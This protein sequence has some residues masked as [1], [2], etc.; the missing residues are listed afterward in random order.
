MKPPVP[1][2]TLILQVLTPLLLALTGLWGW[3]VYGSIHRTILEGFDRKLLALSGGTAAFID[4]DAHAVYQRHRTI[5]TLTGGPGGQLIGWDPA[6]VELLSI[7]PATGGALPLTLRTAGPI[8][9]LA[10]S[11][12]GDRLFALSAAGDRLERFALT[13]ALPL[14]PLTPTTRL[15]GIYFERT[16]LSGWQGVQLFRVDPDTGACSPLPIRLPEGVAALCFDAVAN[17]LLGLSADTRA[18]VA[19]DLKGNVLQ[20]TPFETA[21][22]SPDSAALLP[23]GLALAGDRLF[24]G[25]A[26]LAAIEPA[27]G[28][29][30]QSATSPG[31]LSEDAPFYRQYRDP[32]IAIRNTAHLTYLYTSVY[33]GEDRLYY[34]L[35]GSVG[36]KHSPPGSIDRIPSA[37]G[38][39][40]AQRAQLLGHPWVSPIQKWDQWGLLKTS[41]FPLRASDGRIVALAGADVDISIIREKT[42]WALFA[43]LFVGAGSLIAAGLVSLLITRS[44]TRPL[45]H[46]KE[47]ALRIAAGDYA[48]PAPAAGGHE[49]AGLA[50]ALHRLSERLAEEV[51][52]SRAYQANLHARRRQTTL[53]GALTDLALRGTAPGNERPPASRQIIGAAW[54]GLDGLLWTG[55]AQSDP[56]GTACLRARLIVLARGLLASSLPAEETPALLLASAPTLS[57]CALWQTSARRLDYAARRPCRLRVDNEYHLIEGVGHLVFAGDITCEWEEDASG[58]SAASGGERP[59][60]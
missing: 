26:V 40:G 49:T 13:P 23:H 32:F 50:A 12:A 24:T 51:H 41:S 38:I 58:G 9:S 7:E 8:R 27:T 19:I 11:P 3:F 1:L 25:G 59:P 34:V 37:E 43:V 28:R 31:Y 15:D 56:V 21:A 16:L 47:S 30:E 2:Q 55:P 18:L 52:R 29:L 35:D 57:A 17:Q 54:R 4:A 22:E 6:T 48:T 20:R 60:S 42:R 53:A 45:R 10:R 39:D 44:L 46:L 14:A 36:E 5:T 33:L